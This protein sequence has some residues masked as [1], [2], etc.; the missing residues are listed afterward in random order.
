MYSQLHL[1]NK[2][3]CHMAKQFRLSACAIE[4][5]LMY[6]ISQTS[7]HIYI[8]GLNKQESRENGYMFDHLWV[9]NKYSMSYHR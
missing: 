9:A 8:I 4:T 1:Y 6:S 5:F 3:M 2:E 7:Q